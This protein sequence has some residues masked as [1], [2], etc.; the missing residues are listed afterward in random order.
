MNN[1][2]F[3]PLFPV[4]ARPPE[5][6]HD[7]IERLWVFFLHNP[8]SFL[9]LQFLAMVTGGGASTSYYLRGNS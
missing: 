1:Q 7:F 8:D 6:P 3:L 2:T 5:L 4:L 9:N